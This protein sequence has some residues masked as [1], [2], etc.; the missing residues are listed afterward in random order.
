MAKYLKADGGGGTLD[1]LAEADPHAN[2]LSSD[3]L[4]G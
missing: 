1:P 2:T 3:A 4:H